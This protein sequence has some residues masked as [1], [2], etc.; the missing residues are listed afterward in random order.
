MGSKKTVFLLLC[1]ANIAIS[2]NF[3]ALAAVIPTISQDLRLTDFMVSQILPFYM[4][5]YGIGALFYAPLARRVTY[6]WILIGCLII[7]ALSNL[8]CV[9]KISIQMFLGA[10]ILMGLAAASIIP[11]TLILIGSLFPRNIRGR[12]VG[13]FFSTS[14]I[15]SV[16]GIALSGLCSWHWL[17]V[18]PGILGLV[19]ALALFLCRCPDLDEKAAVAIDYSKMLTNVRLRNIMLFIF[20]ISFLFHGVHKWLGVYLS[21][22]YGLEQF[23]ISFFFILIALFGALGQNLGGYLTDKKGRLITTRWG[24]LI[25]SVA[26][27]L[28]VLRVPLVFLGVILGLFSIGW[29]IGHNGI[30]TVLTDF[31]DQDRLEIAGFNSAVRFV[32]GGM[33]FFVGGPFIER[34]FGF[35]FLGV[36]VLMF[37]SQV[38]LKTIIPKANV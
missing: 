26:T 25:L 16:L 33:G 9:Q 36:G 21:R 31:P 14:F 8:V 24:I 35:T 18:I 34:N 6:K 10:R 17:F 4:I 32:S 37:L 19:A 27:M 3:A 29:T 22:V 15:A 7:Y 11:L 38:F 20:S 1:L 12:M 23:Q 13:L 30:S 28:L 5:P 2:F